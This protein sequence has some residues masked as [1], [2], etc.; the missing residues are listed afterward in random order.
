MSFCI[1]DFEQIENKNGDA[2]VSSVVQDK[3]ENIGDL[4]SSCHEGEKSLGE[5]K[6]DNEIET[7]PVIS[8]S[9]SEDGSKAKDVSKRNSM[10]FLTDM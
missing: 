4:A 6:A 10:I 1:E 5:V 7:T 2:T 8:S 3:A 9:S